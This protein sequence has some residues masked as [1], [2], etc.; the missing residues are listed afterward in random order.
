M[1]K[2]QFREYLEFEGVKEG[3][4][5]VKRIKKD[6]ATGMKSIGKVQAGMLAE[7]QV[8]NLISTY[9]GFTVKEMSPQMDIGFGADLQISYKQGDNNFSFFLDVTTTNKK[10]AQYLTINGRTTTSIEEAFGYQTDNFT[11]YFGIKERHYNRFF[12]E[13]PVVVLYFDNYIA[14]NELAVS[15]VNNI[16][17]LLISLNSKLYSMGYGARAS[18]LVLPNIK[19]YY[20]EYTDENNKQQLSTGKASRETSSSI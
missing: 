8:T 19:R 15:H 18:T 1:W 16:A 10:I 6:K 3:I 7:Q 11:A 13:K 14:S 20:K 9:E 17:N 5:E 4:K 12:Y 2:V